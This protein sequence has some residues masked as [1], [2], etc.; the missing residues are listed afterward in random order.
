MCIRTF[1]KARVNKQ[2]LAAE[3]KRKI[4]KGYLLIQGTV[5]PPGVSW[6]KQHAVDIRCL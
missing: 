2:K 4:E 5:R 6:L 1:T 3:Q